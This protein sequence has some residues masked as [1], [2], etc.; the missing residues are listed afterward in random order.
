MVS[1]G[2]ARRGEVWQDRCVKAGP[3]QVRLW[4]GMAGKVRHG[5]LCYGTV[6]LCAV[7]QAWPGEAWRGTVRRV[8]EEQGMVWCGRRG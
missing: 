1:C 4:S 7:R 2:K 6:G 8:V 5:K 3:G